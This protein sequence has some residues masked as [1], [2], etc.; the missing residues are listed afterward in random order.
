[1]VRIITGK[2][3]GHKL[4]SN[5]KSTVRP[6]KD[7]VKESLFAKL[8]SVEGSLVHKNIIDLFAGTGNLG[9]EALS[10]GVDH[11]T[12]VEKDKQQV[13]LIKQNAQ[14]L[15]VMNNIEIVNRD[16]LAYLR[17]NPPPADII[18]ADPPY[19]YPHMQLF[20]DLCAQLINR[21]WIVIELDRYMEIRG[22]LKANIYTEKQFGKTKIVF[23]RMNN[24]EDSHLSRDF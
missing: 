22:S 19:A 14:K 23:F 17:R 11:V 18:F 3:K 9:F 20:F 10:R 12:F 21:G 4:K 13:E 8:L 24:N 1:M 16:V 2:F 5:Q 7:R 15:G 6:T